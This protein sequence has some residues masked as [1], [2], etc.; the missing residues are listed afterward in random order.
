MKRKTKS[1]TIIIVI[2]A[3][4]GAAFAYTQ[5]TNPI[6]K[7]AQPAHFQQKQLLLKVT[8]QF[9]KVKQKKNCFILTT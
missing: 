6:E 1:T 2:A 4:I 5:F 8:E 9:S 7:P 3:I